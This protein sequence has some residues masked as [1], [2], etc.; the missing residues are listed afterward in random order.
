M[1]DDEPYSGI[2]GAVPYALRASDSLLFRSYAVIGTLL[3]VLVALLFTFALVVLFS[4]TVGVGGGT[5][6][7]SRA[8]FVFVG[9]LVVGPLIAPVLLVARG[10]RRGTASARYDAAMGIAGYLFVVSLYLGLVISTPASQQSTVTG[11]GAIVVDA[12]YA[13]PRIAGLVPPLLAVA[14]QWLVYR[15]LG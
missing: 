7:F 14:V 15:R 11:P 6:T 2:I 8:F 13:L 5:F 12:L 1:A 10:R 9:L 3:A 4:R